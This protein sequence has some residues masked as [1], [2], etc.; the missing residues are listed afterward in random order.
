MKL[1]LWVDQFG[2]I[3]RP[4][5]LRRAIRSALLNAL[6]YTDGNHTQ[7]ARLLGLPRSTLL[8]QMK[9]HGIPGVGTQARKDAS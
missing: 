9:L 5:P 1:T 6:A 8:Y 7:A 3:P 2:P 4:Q